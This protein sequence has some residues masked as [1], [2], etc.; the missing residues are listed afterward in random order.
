MCAPTKAKRR[1]NLRL[2]AAYTVATAICAAPSE[3]ASEVA[4]LLV[5]AI[6][7]AT[8]WLPNKMQ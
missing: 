3:H 2:F 1:P 8:W 6:V 4:G 5:T 7:I